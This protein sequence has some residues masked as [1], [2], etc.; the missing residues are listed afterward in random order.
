MVDDEVDR[1]QRIDLVR[2][3]AKRDHRVAHR[4]EIDDRRHAGEVLHQHPRRAERDLVLMFAAIAGPRG[5]RLDVLLL[6]AASVLVAQQVFEH[7]LERER[8]L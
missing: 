4:G 6:D 3:A 7:D 2:I 5:D 1:D 8:K